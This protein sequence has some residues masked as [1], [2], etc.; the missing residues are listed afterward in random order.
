MERHR[1]G[2][3]PSRIEHRAIHVIRRVQV[4]APLWFRLPV[5]AWAKYTTKK[6]M[7]IG[8]RTMRNP[9][10]LK[11]D[12]HELDIRDQRQNNRTWM[13]D[14]HRRRASKV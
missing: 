13:D 5:S 12:E 14:F 11:R 1:S 3:K 10:L 9:I 6:L 7:I 4:L 2:K 8:K